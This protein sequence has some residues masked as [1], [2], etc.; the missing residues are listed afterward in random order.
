MTFKTKREKCQRVNLIDTIV[1][2]MG[3]LQKPIYLK[4]WQCPIKRMESF[5]LHII[6]ILILNYVCL[7]SKRPPC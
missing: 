4:S 6:F 2:F 7:I 3:C 5:F 1:I